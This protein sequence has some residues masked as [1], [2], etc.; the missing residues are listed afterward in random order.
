[1]AL[2]TLVHAPRL[3]SIRAFTRCIPHRHLSFA[4][5]SAHDDAPSRSA[6]PR[7]SPRNAAIF[8]DVSAEYSTQVPQDANRRLQKLVATGQYTT[9]VSVLVDSR[10]AGIEI[11]PSG[12]Y[13]SA[14]QDALQHHRDQ[15][16]TTWLQ[17]LPDIQIRHLDFSA[18]IRI[19]LLYPEANMPLIISIGHIIAAKGYVDVVRTRILPILVRHMDGASLTGFMRT[20]ET[21]AGR[22]TRQLKQSGLGTKSAASSMNLSFEQENGCLFLTLASFFEVPDEGPCLDKKFFS[23]QH[24]ACCRNEKTGD[25]NLFLQ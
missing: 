10:D 8:E 19:L 1:M 7:P 23:S 4:V 5:H 17:L 11:E 16:F 9:A 3:L 14:A 13:I 21:E 18:I 25:F 6:T 2:R 12:I 20:I 22:Y 24:G 15:D